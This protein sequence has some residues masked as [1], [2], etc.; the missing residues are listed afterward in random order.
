MY[1]TNYIYAT[2]IVIYFCFSRFGGMS[3]TVTAVREDGTI[4]VE[5]DGYGRPG[6][7]RIGEGGGDVTIV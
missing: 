1:T 2:G 5:G 6:R 4:N 3:G 7:H